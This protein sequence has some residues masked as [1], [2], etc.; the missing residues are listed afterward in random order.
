MCVCVCACVRVRAHAHTVCPA[1]AACVYARAPQGVEKLRS[2]VCCHLT[3]NAGTCPG[4]FRGP[5]QFA[6]PWWS[7]L[8]LLL[9]VL[10]VCVVGSRRSASL[11]LVIDPAAL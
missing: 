3:F 10:E 5:K 1:L 7:K 4:L 8:Y 6:L 2:V 9:T 11:S